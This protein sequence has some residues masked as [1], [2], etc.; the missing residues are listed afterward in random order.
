MYPGW[1]SLVPSDTGSYQ[2][3]HPGTRPALTQLLRDVVQPL[4][5]TL[6]HVQQDRPTRIAVLESFASQIFASRGTQGWSASWEAD[7]HLV[8]QYAQLQPR[9]LYDE[10]V[11]RD[12]LA[13]F[14]VLVMP[15]C[16]VLTEAVARAIEH[17]QTRGGIIVADENVA[18]RIVPDILLESRMRT[19]RPDE[20]K[21]ALQKLARALRHDLDPYIERYGDSDNQK[22]I[23]RFRQYGE[24][25]YLFAVND[26]RTFGDYVGHHG[27]VMEQGLSSSARLSVRRRQGVVYDLVQH[28]RVSRIDGGDEISF[29][30]EFGP[31]EGGLYLIVDKPVTALDLQVPA[32]ASVADRVNIVIEV[33]DADGPLAAVLPLR[34]DI[35]DPQGRPAE[36]S[37]AY[38]A[39]DGRLAV[40]LDLATN[41][42]P[43][44]WTVRATEGASGLTAEATVNV[45]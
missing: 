23:L 12:G 4:G 29:A 30:A 6:L 41:D 37:G 21:A 16:D 33:R 7:V 5:P 3:T 34:L 27:R 2:F 18:P 44:L 31:G 13:E 45:P 14:D 28:R 32:M 17:F 35:T 43:G 39:I 19:G 10:T 22:V 25:D 1:G 42:L 40:Q 24:A 11:I 8:L 26:H 36:F 38:A 15:S 20:D 9:I